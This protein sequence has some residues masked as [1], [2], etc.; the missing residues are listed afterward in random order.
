MRR[1]EAGSRFPPSSH[2]LS[3]SVSGLERDV[4]SS[5]R[6][7][8]RTRDVHDQPAGLTFGERGGQAVVTGA[9]LRDAVSSRRGRFTRVR[10]SGFCTCRHQ[11]SCAQGLSEVA[12]ERLLNVG[13]I[14]LGIDWRHVGLF[15]KRKRVDCR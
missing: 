14:K 12:N 11:S 10:R 7:A 6:H 13:L 1:C 4:H 3:L 5:G 9:R 2:R 15:I 8:I